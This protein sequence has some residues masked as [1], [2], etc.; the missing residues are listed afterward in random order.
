MCLIALLATPLAAGAA[1]VKYDYPPTPVRADE[2][3]Q[4]HDRCELDG[5]H[6]G[7][8]QRDADRLG[9]DDGA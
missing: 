8:E 9:F 2:S 7:P 5:Q 6:I 4:Q 3:C 1:D